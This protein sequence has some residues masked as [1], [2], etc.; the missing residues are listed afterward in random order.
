MMILSFDRD[1][2]LGVMTLGCWTVRS[3]SSIFFMEFF[4]ETMRFSRLRFMRLLPAPFQPSFQMYAGGSEMLSRFEMARQVAADEAQRKREAVKEAQEA[5]HRAEELSKQEADHLA[6]IVALAKRLERA[7]RKLA[8]ELTK[9]REQGIRDFLDGNVG[10]EWLKK[11]TEDGLE[12]YELVFQKA[13]EMFAQQFPDVPLDDFVPPPL[14]SPSGETVMPL[15]A[16]EAAA[17]HPPGEENF[18]ALSRGSTDA[19]D[20]KEKAAVQMYDRLLNLASSA[21]AEREFKKATSKLWEEPY[22]QASLWRPCADREAPKSADRELPR[23]LETEYPGL[24]IVTLQLGEA[25]AAKSTERE[26]Q[27]YLSRSLSYHRAHSA[28]EGRMI[29]CNAVAVASL[30]NVTLVIPKFLYSNVWKDPSQFGDIYQEE[31]FTNTL[32]NEVDVVKEL[33]PHLRS[34]D[35]VAIG[36]Q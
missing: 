29:V 21:L 23:V 6:K 10:D 25:Q 19:Y 3:R 31:Y 7:K 33:P 20:N 1:G 28:E 13:K 24:D 17:S 9:A 14:V 36:S 4:H 16:G 22:P 35:L 12:I 11:R 30:L 34:L 8:E 18:D 2:H 15:E 5:T 32:K 26:R 27:N